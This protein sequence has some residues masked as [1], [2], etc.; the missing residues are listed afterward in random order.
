MNLHDVNVL[1]GITISPVLSQVDC[2]LQWVLLKHTTFN[3]ECLLYEAVQQ[4]VGYQFS[5]LKLYLSV[6]DKYIY[7]R[8]DIYFFVYLLCFILV[9]TLSLNKRRFQKP[10]YAIRV[11]LDIFRRVI[12]IFVLYFGYYYFCFNFSGFLVFSNLFVITKS[13]LFFKFILFLLMF[14]YVSGLTTRPFVHGLTHYEYTFFLGFVLLGGLVSLSSF[15]F[16][17]LFCGLEVLNLS[18]YVLAAIIRKSLAGLEAGTK[19]LLLGSVGTGIFLKGI[20][21]MYFSYGTTSFLDLD[22]VELL[23]VNK[24]LNGQFYL[25]MA[26]LL[27]VMISFFI[28]LGVAPFHAWI[29]DVYGGT[30]L[31]VMTVFATIVKFIVFIVVVSI[32]YNLSWPLLPQWDFFILMF[33]AYSVFVGA[34]GALHQT[35]LKRFFAYSSV[36]HVGFLLMFVAFY[37]YQSV[38]MVLLYLFSYIFTMLVILIILLNITGWYKVLTLKDNNYKELESSF[39]VLTKISDLQNLIYTHKSSVLS[40]S[41]LF[42]SL[43]GIPPFLGFFPKLALLKLLLDSQYFFVLLFT[44]ILS[45]VSLGYYLRLIKVMMF[46]KPSLLVLSPKG[47]NKKKSLRESL[48]FWHEYRFSLGI[49]VWV[50]IW[51]LGLAPLYIESFYLFLNQI[52]FFVI[53]VFA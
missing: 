13:V 31:P 24:S 4:T 21:L 41:L 35:S 37:N 45:I 36:N 15:D 5:G 52:A 50:F 28:K 30:S 34:M 2:L 11:A 18:L 27:L 33:G 7:V 20:A 6:P 17:P 44:I 26:G 47:T 12:L 1:V 8:P 48:I 10:G 38:T 23:H 51:I 9:I 53:N 49:L 22:I 32:L 39:F 25:L 42:F 3:N 16:L 19:Y 14:L 40:L 46:D 43:G 29:V